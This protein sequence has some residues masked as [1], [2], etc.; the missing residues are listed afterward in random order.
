MG[1]YADYIDW[2]GDT[3]HVAGTAETISRNVSMTVGG[4]AQTAGLAGG[5]LAV[6]SA[7]TDQAKAITTAKVG[8]VEITLGDADGSSIDAAAKSQMVEIGR[9]HV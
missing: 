3:L 8:D 2:K 4:Q 9:A 1:H 5:G 7:G 6:S